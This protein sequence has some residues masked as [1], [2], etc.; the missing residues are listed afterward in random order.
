M[1][2]TFVVKEI[3]DRLRKAEN[4]KEALSRDVVRAEGKAK[5]IELNQD[6]VSIRIAANFADVTP[7]GRP[8]KFASA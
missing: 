1:S 4:D 3:E 6:Q 2:H 5:Q 8:T 7:G